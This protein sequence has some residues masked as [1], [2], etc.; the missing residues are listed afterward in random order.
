MRIAD[1]E[2]DALTN[3]FIGRKPARDLHEHGLCSTPI[4]RP[5]NPAAAASARATTPVPH[6]TSRMSARGAK[7]IFST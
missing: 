2:L 3:A 1:A 6:P 7:A 4:T 5:E